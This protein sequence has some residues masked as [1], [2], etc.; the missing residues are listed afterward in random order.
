MARVRIVE[1]MPKGGIMVEPS[2]LTQVEIFEGLQTQQLQKLAAISHEVEYGQGDMIFRENMPGDS[3]YIVL[4]GE[5][6]ILVDPRI[7]G[8][9]LPQEAK[10]APITVIRRGQS[11]GEVALVDSGVRSASAVCASERVQLLAIPRETF[12]QVCQKDPAIGYRVMFNIAAD[13]ASRIRTT[14]FI[15]RGRLLL[16]SRE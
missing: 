14:D 12:L 5:V 16:G 11:F 2:A 7:L 10:P 13:L 8:E 9:D 4:D 15:L 6:E 3:M 1:I